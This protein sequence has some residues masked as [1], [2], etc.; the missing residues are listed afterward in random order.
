[1]KNIAKKLLAAALALIMV[2]SLAACQGNSEKSV[3]STVKSALTAI[4]KYDTKKI[5]KLIES[6]T[7]DALEENLSLLEDGEKLLK[8]LFTEFEFEIGETVVEKEKEEDGVSATA[9]CDVLIKN[10]DIQTV[11]STY[12][13]TTIGGLRNQTIDIADKEYQKSEVAKILEKLNAEDVKKK[14]YNVQINLE[15]RKG[16]WIVVLGGSA[17]SAVFG[18]A[19]APIQTIL[20]YIKRANNGTLDFVTPKT[21]SPEEKTSVHPTTPAVTE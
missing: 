21:T 19:S 18:G 13:L 1:M 10:R 11:A 7:F 5:N 20:S 8:V 3:Q 14:E 6:N 2:F 12:L 17:E 4:K 16:K 9:T 15:K